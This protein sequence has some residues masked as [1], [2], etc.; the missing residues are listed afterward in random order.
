MKV[1]EPVHACALAVTF[2]HCQATGIEMMIQM[3]PH[4]SDF[5]NEFLSVNALSDLF[6][7]SPFGRA[8]ATLD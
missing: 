4:A 6:G 1:D 7:A 3:L 8:H 2:L 5:Y